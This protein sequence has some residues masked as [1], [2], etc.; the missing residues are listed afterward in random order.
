[1][2][3]RSRKHER[4][5][6]ILDQVYDG[7]PAEWDSWGRHNLPR[8]SEM[9]WSLAAKL[10]LQPWDVWKA[11]DRLRGD[12]RV[13]RIGRGRYVKVGPEIYRDDGNLAE[14]LE[15]VR[16]ATEATK[17][18]HEALARMR[19]PLAGPKAALLRLGEASAALK[20]AA[21]DLR[22]TLDKET[23]DTP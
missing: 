22:M 2:A 23:H 20:L 8:G 6:A 7:L 9:V 17:V 15:M 13:Q 16:W 12:S 11:I 3:R 14:G 1:M 5:T 21:A 4:I 19:H 18:A 10:G